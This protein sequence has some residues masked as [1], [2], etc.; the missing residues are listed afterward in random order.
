MKKG[1][2]LD[3]TIP[4]IGL[5]IMILISLGSSGQTPK[6]SNPF[7][8]QQSETYKQQCSGITKKGVQCKIY[9][10]TTQNSGPKYCHFHKK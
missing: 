8:P 3:L 6:K 4:F 10:K 1:T 2:N 9:I 7:P 5:L